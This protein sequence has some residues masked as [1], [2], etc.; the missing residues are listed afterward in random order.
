MVY[1]NEASDDEIIPVSIWFEDIDKTELAESTME[2]LDTLIDSE[3]LPLGVKNSI[4]QST[5]IIDISKSEAELTIEEIQSIVE[6]ERNNAKEIY[7]EYNA[8]QFEIISEN[9]ANF[10]LIYNCKFAPNIVIETYKSN[11]YLLK[12]YTNITNLFNYD[13]DILGLDA[14]YDDYSASESRT[15]QIN[16]THCFDAISS[17]SHTGD[18]IKIGMI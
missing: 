8:E 2:S 10:N 12:D 4:N 6:A 15:V 11:I 16:S 18:N 1:V 17:S 13:E 5:A 7:L 3:Q 14:N 9:L